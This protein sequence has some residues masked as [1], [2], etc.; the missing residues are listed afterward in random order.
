MLQV[1]EIMLT[2]V[3]VRVPRPAAAPD[4]PA[5]E[6]LAPDAVEPVEPA[7][8]VEPVA[9]AD[10]V[11][12]VEPA[13]PVEAVADDP[14]LGADELLIALSLAD[15]K[16]P[17]TVTWWPTC[18]AR[19]TEASA[20]S[21]MSCDPRPLMLPPRPAVDGDSPPAV[22]PELA[23][24]EDPVEPVAPLA[25]EPLAPEPIEEPLAPPIRAFFRTKVPPRLL[26]PLAEAP[27]VSEPVLELVLDPSARWMQPVAVTVPAVCEDDCPVVGWPACGVLDVG[28]CA[29][30]VPLRAMLLLSAIAHCQTCVFFMIVLQV[31]RLGRAGL[32]PAPA[33]IG[34][35]SD[36]PLRRPPRQ[37]VNATSASACRRARGDAATVQPGQLSTRGPV[38]RRLV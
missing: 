12:P 35:T 21:R 38:F 37:Q 8:P 32:G 24:D 10:P 9:P 30:R 31:D 20:L 6:A 7:E 16:R 25:P 29:A 19:F 3:T 15:P 33:Q 14:L 11:E 23:V 26:L 13:E 5:P 34:A 4:M 2:C 1:D 18:A 28:D 27:A 17:V 36:P 22:A